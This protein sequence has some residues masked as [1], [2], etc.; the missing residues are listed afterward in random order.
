MNTSTDTPHT[1]AARPQNHDRITSDWVHYTI[2][3][4]LERELVDKTNEVA[5]LRDMVMDAA[6]RGDELAAH[7]KERAEKAEAI[8]KSLHNF[9]EIIEEKLNSNLK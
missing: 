6:K 4:M 2:C 7:W 9:A 5:R 3:G 8:I 1:D